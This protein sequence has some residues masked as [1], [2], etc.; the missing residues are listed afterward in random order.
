MKI[1]NTGSAIRGQVNAWKQE[2]QSVGFV[3]TMGNLHQGHEMLLKRAVEQADKVVASIFVNPMQ[4]NNARDYDTYPRTIDEDILI[5]EQLGV[6]TLFLPDADEM[7][8]QGQ[9][10]TTRVVVPGLSDV[11]E[12]E[13]R[14]GHFT[15]VTTVVN[16]LFNLVPADITFFGEKDYQQLMLIQRMV[17]ELNMAIQVKAV[18]TVREADGLAMSSRNSRL[19]AEQR[20]QAPLLYEVLK[21]TADQLLQG[22]TGYSELESSAM[23]ALNEHGF[24]AEYVAIRHANDLSL[25]DEGCQQWAILAAARLGEVR[26]IDNALIDASLNQ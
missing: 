20:Q 8:P 7:Y 11:L 9:Q 4:F 1:Y 25:P 26:L 3:P 2:S 18:P 23:S 6:A 15:G 17:R 14:P 5:L 19:T 13:H 22:E 10:Q 21:S 12:G 16:K 24:Q